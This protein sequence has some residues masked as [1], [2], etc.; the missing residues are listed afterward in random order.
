M[1]KTGS[2]IAR[3]LDGAPFYKAPTA[4][5]LR[6]EEERYPAI[7]FTDVKTYQAGGGVG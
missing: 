5:G 6:Y 2:S 7:R 3:D 1:D 4:Y